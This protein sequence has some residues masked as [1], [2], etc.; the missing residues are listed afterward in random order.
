[1][2]RPAGGFTLI[3]MLLVISIIV[4]LMALLVPQIGA[5]VQAVKVKD[6]EHRIGVIHAV[7]EDYQRTYAAYPPST[8]PNPTMRSTD[9]DSYAPYTYPSGD[10]ASYLFSIPQSNTQHPF[11]GK[12][13][14]YFLMGPNGRG[15]HRPADRTNSSDP[16]YRNRFLTAEWDVPESLSDY[17][18]NTACGGEG[19][20]GNPR[21]RAPCFV[22]AFGIA[23]RDGGLIGYSA[24]NPRLSGTIR[25]NSDYRGNPNHPFNSAYA[26]SC[27][28]GDGRATAHRDRMYG[29]CPYDFVLLSAGPDHFLGWRIYGMDQG[30]MFRK[31]SY[32]DYDHGVTDDIANFPLK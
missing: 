26:W 27:Q 23:G 12:F 1:M 10:E 11:G 2:R 18:R 15:W 14:V 19:S 32:A 21:Y 29:Q 24:A 20:P 7:V 6:T 31:R 4:L 5:V 28:T 16:D 30:G 3:E 25:W 22:D 17:L 8:S 13:L 9:A